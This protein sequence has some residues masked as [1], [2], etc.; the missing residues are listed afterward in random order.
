MMPVVLLH[1]WGMHGGV[2][3]ASAEA[4][5]ERALPVDMSGYGGRATVTPYDLH[6]LA[7]VIAAELPPLFDLCAWSLGG[8]VAMTLA[9]LMPGRVRR[10]V[11]VGTNPCFTTRADWQCGIAPEVLMQFAQDLGN[12]YET[13]LKRFLALQ[14]RGDDAARALLARLRG[15]LFTRGR[16]DIAVLQAGLA[17]LLN[18]DL[19]P[20][21]AQ[22]AAPTMVIHGSFDQLAPVSAAR[23]LA[24][25]L[26][27]A[28][29]QVIAGASHA[30]F[31]SHRTEFDAALSAFLAQ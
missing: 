15:L 6:Q 2:W 31:L 11:L 21:A 7:T 8:Q 1:G 30:P 9:Q 17:I 25:A 19:R 23:W 22:I 24:Q 26:P 29:L 20:L 16:P 4:L 3:A 28:Q 10:L 5:G 18:A 12:N 14:A 13:T 27:D